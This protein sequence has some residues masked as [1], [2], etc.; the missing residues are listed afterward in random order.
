MIV[1]RVKGFNS[2]YVNWNLS[3]KQDY[4]LILLDTYNELQ[5]ALHTF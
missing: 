4:K 1:I 3:I 2:T 5:G